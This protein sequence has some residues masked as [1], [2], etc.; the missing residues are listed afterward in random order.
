MAP[1]DTQEH[2]E[3]DRHPSLRD[4]EISAVNAATPDDVEGV[5]RRDGGRGAWTFLFGA[6]IV[7]ISAWGIAFIHLTLGITPIV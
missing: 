1:Y 6:A 7:E 2:A 3:K 5:A 4:P